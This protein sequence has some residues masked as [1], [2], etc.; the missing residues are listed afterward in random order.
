MM[1]KDTCKWAKIHV[2]QHFGYF[3]GRSIVESLY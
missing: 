1:G 3:E 2:G